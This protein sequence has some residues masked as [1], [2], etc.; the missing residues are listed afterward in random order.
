MSDVLQWISKGGV[1][2]SLDWVEIR[3]PGL[4][5][6]LLT[7]SVAVL[8]VY[9]FR[10]WHG[11]LFL[12][13]RFGNDSSRTYPFPLVFVACSTIS[14]CVSTFNDQSLRTTLTH[15][16]FFFLNFDNAIF[17]FPSQSNNFAGQWTWIKIFRRHLRRQIFNQ[18]ILDEFFYPFW[19][20]CSFYFNDYPFVE[21]LNFREL[22]FK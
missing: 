12:H 22:N 10:I 4:F 18:T 6:R 3:A 11:N 9:S 5:P 8:S 17:L 21:F 1:N 13:N 20:I 16:P 2:V 7:L 15:L 14:V 19:K